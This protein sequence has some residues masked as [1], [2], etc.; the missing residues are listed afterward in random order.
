MKTGVDAVIAAI[1]IAREQH[2]GQFRE[3]T[4]GPP[5]PYSEH[6]LDVIEILRCARAGAAYGAEVYVVAALHDI[7][8]DTAYK[9]K[10]IGAEFGALVM[11]AVE[12]LTLPEHAKRGPAKNEH[13][14]AVMRDKRLPELVRAVKIADKTSN[15]RDLVKYAPDWSVAKCEEYVES[16]RAVVAAAL[17]S[18][19]GSFT[20]SVLAKGFY[21]IANDASA[22]IAA[23][24]GA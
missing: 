12:A 11:Q 17:E 4:N 6:V 19:A 18:S 24:K 20:V 7:V 8:E 23:R 1:S 15:V 22:I 9:P 13:Q 3:R 5:V 2:E 14:Q 16:A 10:Y 21:V